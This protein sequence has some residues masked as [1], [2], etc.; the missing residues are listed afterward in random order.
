MNTKPSI[1][2]VS[3]DKLSP[4][5][6]NPE[7]RVEEHRLK[8]L[9]ASME[10]HGFLSIFP[11]IAT[12]DGTIADGHRRWAVARLLGIDNVPVIYASD[13]ISLS[14]YWALNPIAEPLRATEV[15]EAYTKG[16]TSLPQRHAATIE[17]LQ[18]ALGGKNE[19]KKL[20]AK[21][22]FTPAVYQLAK[23]VCN[24]CERGDD[25]ELL[26]KTIIWI[27]ENKMQRNMSLIAHNE[28][29]MDMSIVVKAIDENRPL[30]LVANI[31]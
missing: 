3:P 29:G 27:V 15:L 30:G 20:F 26:A 16:M 25:A 11:I 31:S 24:K 1:V 23:R 2:F 18:A 19:L 28:V 5:K 7:S 9:K 21:G 6:F 10:E 22:K 8:Y 12:A 13:S 14:E 17:L 4:A